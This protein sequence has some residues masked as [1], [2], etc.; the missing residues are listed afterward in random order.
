[1]SEV[2]LYLSRDDERRGENL[3]SG[4]QPRPHPPPSIDYMDTSP[5]RKHLLLGPYSRLVHRAL[6]EGGAVSFGP[7]MVARL[8]SVRTP[9]SGLR[10]LAH[11]L[12]W[13]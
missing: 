4:R 9:P 2:P 1:M 7:Y 13:C 3:A 12:S 11:S 10:R 6:V 8:V 5:I